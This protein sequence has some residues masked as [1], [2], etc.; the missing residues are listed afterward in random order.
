[1]IS[2]SCQQGEKPQ[3]ATPSI[4]TLPAQKEIIH[5]AEDAFSKDF[6]RGMFNPKT[7]EDFVEIDNKYADRKGLYMQRQA[8]IDFIRMWEQAKAE[9]I[10]L[11]IRSAARNFNRQRQ[12][13]EAKW[14]GQ[15]LTDKGENLAESTPNPEERALKILQW[16]SMPGTSRHH[17]GTDIDLNNFTNSYFE[18]GKGLQEYDWLLT[19]ASNFGF[20]Q[21]YTAKDQ[22]RPHG[23]NEEKW[24]WSYLPLARDYTEYA[25]LYLKDED[26]T[27]F[28]GS[29]TA[30]SIGIKQKYILGISNVCL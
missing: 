19:N 14:T 2:L 13:W 17:W 24:H 18:K 4:D 23:Y 26:I 16:S 27:G 15:R 5:I 20:C 29:G 12:I 3:Q 21:V 9:G 28:L 8:Y 7:H 11:Q 1:L 30:V 25:R 10:N 22:K 6:I